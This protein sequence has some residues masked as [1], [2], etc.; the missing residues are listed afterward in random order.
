MNS[1]IMKLRSKIWMYYRIKNSMIRLMSK[2]NRPLL[3]LI[4]MKTK[5]I[6]FLTFCK[7]KQSVKSKYNR[8][9]I[10]N[11]K[12][13]NFYWA[14]P[15]K[16]NFLK[17]MMHKCKK[18]QPNWFKMATIKILRIKIITLPCKIWKTK[19]KIFWHKNYLDKIPKI[20][21]NCNKHYLKIKLIL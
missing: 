19:H 4:K 18:F 3:L 17:M 10:I 16:M 8:Q 13:Y 6:I 20:Y 9:T 7:I 14:K 1:L 2:T 11:Y 15:I 5:I 21:N 12:N